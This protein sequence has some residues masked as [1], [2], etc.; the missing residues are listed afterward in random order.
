MAI[1][2]VHGDGVVPVAQ[3]VLVAGRLFLLSHAAHCQQHSYE[4][5]ERQQSTEKSYQFHSGYR[6]FGHFELLD[7]VNNIQPERP[8][9]PNT[10]T[11]IPLPHSIKPMESINSVRGL[12][13]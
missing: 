9:F 1:E 12:Q 2:V 10:K 8:L 4:G 11:L 3:V 5:E 7:C 13:W 6:T